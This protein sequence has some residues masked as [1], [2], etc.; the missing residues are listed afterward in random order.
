M[1]EKKQG[2]EEEGRRESVRSVCV[3]VCERERRYRRET[4]SRKVKKKDR[5]LPE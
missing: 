4:E 2:R 1:R 3:C 5:K